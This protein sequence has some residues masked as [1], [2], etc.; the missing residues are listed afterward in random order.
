MYPLQTSATQMAPSKWNPA[1]QEVQFVLVPEHESQGES[2][3]N[4]QV[5]SFPKSVFK[6][7]PELQTV[8]NVAV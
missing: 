6:R 7:Y 2:H 5:P 1:M 8:Q 3:P 4:V